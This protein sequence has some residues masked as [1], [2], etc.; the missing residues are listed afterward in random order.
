[1]SVLMDEDKKLLIKLARSAIENKLDTGSKIDKPK[2]TSPVLDEKRG[3]FVS[4]H[5]NG[6]LRGCIGVIENP[7]SLVS[8]VI[9]NALSAAFHDPRFSPLTKEELPDV[10]IEVSVL[11]VPKILDFKDGEDLKR[12]LKPGVHGVILS[13]GYNSATF[14]PQVWNQF[15]DKEE[16][17][18]ALCL[19]AGMERKCWM[20]KK[21][22]VMIYEAEY[23]S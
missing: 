17:L 8:G 16:F 23:F 22:T 2:E 21:T 15:D 12:K 11:T 4:L 3:C 10:D 9:D 5:K 6:L 13:R 20:N 19:K 7:P 1:M 18:E 14:L